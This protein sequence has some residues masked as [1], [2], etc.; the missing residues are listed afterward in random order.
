MAR[1]ADPS[2]VPAA[3]ETTH[4]E[5]LRPM[6]EAAVSPADHL[7]EIIDMVAGFSSVHQCGGAFDAAPNVSCSIC[8]YIFRRNNDLFQHLRIVHIKNFICNTYHQAFSTR[9]EYVNHKRICGQRGFG[10]YKPTS[11]FFHITVKPALG[12]SIVSY[13]CTPKE[14]TNDLVRVCD[15]FEKYSR[16]V[17]IQLLREGPLKF[18]VF[19]EC[20]F[21]K[22][23]L[24]D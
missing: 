18:N 11:N 4:N 6:S 7:Q 16:A 9:A 3:A 14:I 22:A 21:Y 24:P 15:K 5:N 23:L 1:V 8:G 20:T 12:D 19:V 17:L 10:F 13:S 2:Q